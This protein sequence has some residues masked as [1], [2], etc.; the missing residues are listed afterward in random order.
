MKLLYL[1]EAGLQRHRLGL[2]KLV[3]IMKLSIFL[4]IAACL[5]ANAKGHSQPI[6]LAMHNVPLQKV[7]KAIESQSGYQF[8]YT[9][10]ALSR[11]KHVNIMIKDAS[12]QDVL[13]LCFKDQQLTY[14]IIEKT[15]VVKVK[16][17]P[18]PK[19]TINDQST[20]APVPIPIPITGRVVDENNKP[21]A[22]ASVTVKNTNIGTT[23]NDNGVFALNVS[24]ENAVLEISFVGYVTKTI[25]VG[26]N[27]NFAIVLS[28]ENKKLEDFVVIG[29]QTVRKRDLTGATSVVNT[30]NTNKIVAGSVAEQLQGMVPGV[31]VRNTGN[32]NA[33]PVVEIRGVASFADANPLYVIDGMIAD[34]NSTI[35]PDDIATIQILK[36]ASAAAI[37]GSRA[38]NG[39]IIITTKKGKTGP[40]KV[41]FS[42]RYGVEQI[43][44]KWDVMDAPQYLQTLKTQYANSNAPLPVGVASQLANNTI[45]TDWQNAFERAGSTQDY[46]L[47]I[48]GGSANGTYYLSGGYFKNKGV[49]I[50]NNFERGSLRFNTELHKGRVTVGENMLLSNTDGRYPGAGINAFYESATSSPIIAVQSPSYISSV[51]NPQGWGFGSNDV[52]QYSYNYAAVSALNPQHFNHSKIVGNGYIDVKLAK[53]LNYRFNAGLEASFDQL[54]SQRDSG[55]WRYNADLPATSITENR[56]TF[57]NYLLEHTLNFN[58]TF[59]D[60]S[61][62][63]VIGYSYQQ[64]KQ[65]YTEASRLNLVTV[66]GQTYTTISSAQGSPTSSGGVPLFYRLQGYLG[67]VNYNYK[68]RYLLTVSDRVDQDSRFGANYRTGNFYSVAASWRTSRENFFRS[69]WINDLKIRGSYGQLGISSALQV[70]AG[71]WPTVGYINQNQRAIY[72]VNQTPLVG[73]SQAIISNPNLRWEQRNEANIGFDASILDNRV[74]VTADIYNNLSK[75]VLV[76]VPLP[77]FLGNDNGNYNTFITENAASIRN[78]GVEVSVSY[79]HN[80][81]PFKWDLSV[82]G[83]S[84][85][86][87]VVSVGNQGAGINYIEAASFVRSEIGHPMSSWYV[88]KTAGIFQ[89][90]AEVDSYKDKNGNKI[91]PNAKPGDIKFVDLNG[92][93]QIN[94]ADRTFAGS[95]WPTFQSGLQF[96]GTY[97]QFSVN[98]QFVGVFGYKIYD[99]V[100]RVLD[101]YSNLNNFRSDLNPWSSTN[102]SGKDPRLGLITDPGINDNNRIESDRWLENGSY[103]R[104][105]NLE[106]GYLLPAQVTKNIGFNNVHV[107]VSGQNLFTVTKYKG[108]DPDVTGNG[109]NLRGVDYGNWPSSRII[110]FGISG[111]F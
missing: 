4:M 16:K 73:E 41:N 22:G 105:R 64:E 60:H 62:N 10:R 21:I 14:T 87:R 75:G 111:E 107:Y 26:N 24:D 42:A 82:N 80:G 97:K 76:N 8:L 40:N 101:S 100:R 54:V 51:S 28:L 11:A 38:A 31:T 56:S 12:L 6:S 66:G 109:V 83:T 34:A 43:P 47:G 68:D 69:T 37:Y 53:W 15:I 92:D 19:V 20:E 90:Q 59:G 63:G 18:D 108:L 95:P 3:R 81:G 50:G 103:I 7:F 89:T 72:G 5:T 98:M 46:N 71:S 30:E 58:K 29:Y 27:R 104:L 49:L 102:T 67:R 9:N 36:D 35:N 17:E 70:L 1:T 96:N 33:A 48:S 2:T 110:S 74:Q 93:G 78:R 55:I 39:V 23:T 106:L 85:Q 13:T 61:I 91:Q 79:K 57:T 77:F 25:A 88:I 94:N 52:P 84:I 86:N 45:N 99:D 32:P 65:E 44:N